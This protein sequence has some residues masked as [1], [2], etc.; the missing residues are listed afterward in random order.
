MRMAAFIG[1]LAGATMLSTAAANATLI[2]Q[3]TLSGGAQVPPV[4]TPATG[5]ATVTLE[6]DNITLDVDVTFSGLTGGPA[7]AAHIHCCAAADANGPVALPFS[8]FPS[9]TSGTYIQSF[10]LNTDLTGITV[11]AFLAALESGQAYINI[12]DATFP[13]GEI[14]G[15]LALVPEPSVIGILGLGAVAVFATRRRRSVP[16]PVNG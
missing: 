12:H 15:Q 6:N 8:G 3:T 5:S 14:R 1:V 4:S 9:T 10:D 11:A 13:S 16:P 2:F 7:N